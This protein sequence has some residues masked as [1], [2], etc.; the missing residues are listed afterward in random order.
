MKA[1]SWKERLRDDTLLSLPLVRLLTLDWLL[2]C[3]A[4]L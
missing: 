4:R 2:G 3:A 1:W